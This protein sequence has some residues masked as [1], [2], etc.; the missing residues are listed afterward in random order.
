M[1]RPYQNAGLAA[2]NAFAGAVI[3][4]IRNDVALTGSRP[5]P[6]P[7]P[8]RPWSPADQHRMSANRHRMLKRSAPL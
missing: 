7:L 5:P 4:I 2:A 8:R 3:E 6:E 1:T